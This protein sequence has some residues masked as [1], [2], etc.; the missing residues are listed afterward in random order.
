MTT[1]ALSTIIPMPITRAPM[2]IMFREKPMNFIKRNVT[3]SD[4][5]MELPTIRLPLKSPKKINRTSM[6]I[7]M[8]TTSVCAM[9][10]RESMMVSLLS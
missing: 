7:T 9:E 5:G 2:V 3:S 6:V 1:M 4:T 8:P 10:T